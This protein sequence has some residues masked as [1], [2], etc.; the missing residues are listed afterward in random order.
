MLLS[1]TSFFAIGALVGTNKKVFF[2]NR[3]TH[4]LQL[5]GGLAKIVVLGNHFFNSFILSSLIKMA[6]T[7][8]V[9]SSF[10]FCKLSGKSAKSLLH[11]SSVCSLVKLPI[12]G[13]KVNKSLLL[14]FK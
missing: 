4:N 8:S 13:G 1:A 9:V 12:C 14:A 10:R 5:H 7:S 6:R 3:F 2:K 11:K